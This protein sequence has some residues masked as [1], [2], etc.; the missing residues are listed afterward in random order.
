MLGLAIAI[1]LV[2]ALAFS[3][4]RLSRKRRLARLMSQLPGGH[5][6]NALHVVS[7]EDIDERIRARRCPCGGR[8]E[9]R[10]EGSRVFREKRLRV[11]RVECV[12]C[13]N[14]ASVHFD[15]TELF[16]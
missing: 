13:E 8:Y 4:R 5:A 16:H 15:V 9:V 10:G 12:T 6:R 14:E 7:F 2:V 11:V 3:A 1:A